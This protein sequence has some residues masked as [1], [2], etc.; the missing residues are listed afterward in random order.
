MTI[1]VVVNPAAGGGRLGQLWPTLAVALERALGPL[2]VLRTSK[3]GEGRQLAQQHLRSGATLVISAGGDGTANE[4]VD[5]LLGA[6]GGPQ[7]GVI[8]VGTGRDFIRTLGGSKDL[9]TAVAAIGSGRSRAI[10]AGRV[11][12]RSDTG[13]TETRHFLNVASIGVSGPTVRAVNAAKHGRPVHAKAA[14]YFHTVVELMRYQPQPVRVTF[15]DGEVIEVTTAL[16]VAANGRY[17]G[18]G[19]MVTPDAQIDDGLLDALVYRAEGKLRM[20][21]DFNKIYRGAHTTLP[22]VTI[23]R[24]RSF[25][26]EPLGEPL[27]LEA[28]GESP[29][30]IPAMFEVLPKALVLRG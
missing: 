4:V 11:T 13:S 30:R 17:F 12:Y 1:G 22:R 10:D 29:G 28:D 27:I 26:I 21:L 5:G 3:P 15:D 14:F 8:S 2:S 16:V 20:V 9:D 23:K 6:G 7:L 19:M 24:C 18:G 25:T